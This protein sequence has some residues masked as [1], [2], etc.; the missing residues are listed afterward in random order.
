MKIL[1]GFLI[2]LFIS[3]QAYAAQTMKQHCTEI[4]REIL[5][6][7]TKYKQTEWDDELNIYMFHS[8][9]Y[10]HLDCSDFR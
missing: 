1:I 7:Y 2:A 9:S 6:A 4:E 3:S 8:K 5:R 10:H